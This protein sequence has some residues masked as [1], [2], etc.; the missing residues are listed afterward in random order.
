MK[1]DTQIPIKTDKRDVYW[2]Y[3]N[4]IVAGKI[5]RHALECTP[6]LNCTETAKKVR[7]SAR[8]KS[9]RK[10]RQEAFIFVDGQKFMFKE[11]EEGIYTLEGELDNVSI[12]SKIR[13]RSYAH[14]VLEEL[15]FSTDYLSVSVLD[16]SK[17][18]PVQ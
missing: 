10:Q 9:F 4:A 2:L 17:Y 15:V 12:R 6:D 3:D 14:A 13:L 11:A 16:N 1:I 5:Q 7:I 18:T 8:L